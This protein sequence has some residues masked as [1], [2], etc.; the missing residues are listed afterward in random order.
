M[1]GIPSIKNMGIIG[2]IIAVLAYLF[3]DNP[4][5]QG[6]LSMFT[7]NE[8]HAS[9]KPA[10][11]S[12][13][14]TSSSG[15]LTTKQTPEEKA[16]LVMESWKQQ[17]EAQK[18]PEMVRQVIL[19]N[20]PYLLKQFEEAFA[21]SK[22]DKQLQDKLVGIQAEA[23]KPQY[24]T[25]VKKLEQQVNDEMDK[26]I[27]DVGKNA[28]LP[29]DEKA[30]AIKALRTEKENLL[31]SVKEETTK[32]P[33]EHR[34][35]MALS[36]E[37]Q[38]KILS[39]RQEALHTSSAKA[40]QGIEQ[41]AQKH[42]TRNSFFG[43]VG[44]GSAEVSKWSAYGGIAALVGAGA[45]WAA[46]G[47]MT[48]TGVGAVAGVPLMAAG[49][50][51]GVSAGGYMLAASTTTGLVAGASHIANGETLKG[52]VETAFSLPGLRQIGM[53]GRIGSKV[54]TQVTTEASQLVEKGG[55]IEAS[56]IL[57][58]LWG[59]ITG[60][61]TTGL[62]Q[63]GLTPFTPAATV[64]SETAEATF[65]NGTTGF[66]TAMKNGLETFVQN[67]GDKAAQA[68]SGSMAKQAEIIAEQ[69]VRNGANS[70]VRQTVI[71]GG[72]IGLGSVGAME[73]GS[74]GGMASD[75]LTPTST[76]TSKKN[77]TPAKTT[78]TF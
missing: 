14:A 37:G 16:A 35:A 8:A 20:E 65:R 59:S 46:G 41:I 58:R 63:A 62:G 30:K 36:P 34:V 73:L 40:T 72:L 71:N 76:P 7:G 9:E 4:L 19:S 75:Y 15:G 53:T 70:Y 21:T 55:A 27:R 10:A 11:L 3:R 6:L 26:V 50:S 52:A 18:T 47:L 54:A 42:A 38:N 64:I 57:G 28:N 69:A 22:T 12:A 49:T 44:D 68:V 1:F 43:R 45:C 61:G 33:P 31:K 23:T 66:N 77:D 51:L 78:S 17:M 2:A 13:G 74:V 25:F 5:I 24:D 39:D 32:M 48:A 60:K 67:T 29:A 56:T